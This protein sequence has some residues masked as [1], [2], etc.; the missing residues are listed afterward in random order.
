MPVF[1]PVV[2][3]PVFVKE[4]AANSASAAAKGGL[5]AS[6]AS[7][8]ATQSITQTQSAVITGNNNNV[9]NDYQDAT[10]VVHTT[11]NTAVALGTNSTAQNQVI[12]EV[13][14]PDGT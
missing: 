13:V 1:K 14:T 9:T 4:P 10:N 5:T 6:A 2:K 7:T 3:E 8:A 12:N 11:I